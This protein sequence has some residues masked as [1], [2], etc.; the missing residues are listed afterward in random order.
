M[1]IKQPVTTQLMC[2]A[3]VGFPLSKRFWR[4]TAL[5]LFPLRPF[6]GGERSAT[7]PLHVEQGFTTGAALQYLSH[8]PRAAACVFL[9]RFFL[10]IV[11]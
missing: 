5:F 7:W 8:P 2:M 10:D 3:M 6:S 1:P 4:F 11:R 9:A